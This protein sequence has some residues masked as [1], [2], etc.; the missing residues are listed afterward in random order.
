MYL[1]EWNNETNAAHGHGV[2]VV[3]DGQVRT[4]GAAATVHWHFMPFA[5]VQ[6]YAGGLVNGVSHGIAALIGS[7]SSSSSSV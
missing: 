7:G 2:I 6:V 4:A 3:D 1:G 5:G